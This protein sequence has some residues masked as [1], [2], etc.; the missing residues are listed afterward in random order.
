MIHKTNWQKTLQD[1]LKF[2]S[3][4]NQ[5]WSVQNQWDWTVAHSEYHF[6]DT[7]QDQEGEWFKVLG[8]FEGDFKEE[9]DRLIKESKT[10]WV[11]PVQY[12]YKNED[13]VTMLEQEEYDIAQGDDDPNRVILTN[14]TDD[15]TDYPML[16]KMNNSFGV[17]GEYDGPFKSKSHVQLPGQMFNLHI[18]KLWEIC[19]E[20]PEQICRITILLE[21]WRPGQFYMYGNYIYERWK[22]GE[23]HIFDWAN[24]PHA[25]ANASN[26]PRPTLQITGLKSDLTREIIENG[27][28]DVIWKI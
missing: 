19:E 24:V 7:I 13:E 6:D 16:T 15:L 4:S 27:S 28:S 8:R 21:D 12:S 18:D 20:D 25:T 9:S 11:S 14:M 23:A 17:L 22:A 26:Y 3:N 2:K 10:V 1:P 5:S